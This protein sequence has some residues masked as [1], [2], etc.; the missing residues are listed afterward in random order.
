MELCQLIFRIILGGL[1]VRLCRHLRFDGILGRFRLD[2]R[3][4]FTSLRIRLLWNLSICPY[5]RGFL[6]I[7]LPLGLLLVF[8]SILHEVVWLL[9]TF[10]K[11]C[12]DGVW[13]FWLLPT[14][15]LLSSGT[16]SSVFLVSESDFLIAD[17]FW[18]CQV[19]WT[20]FL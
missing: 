1:R 3:I 10:P 17:I 16:F 20:V 6:K 13:I 18:Y 15:F 7:D 9:L 11:V 5:V 2:L 19:Y 12:H 8:L 4:I 14:S